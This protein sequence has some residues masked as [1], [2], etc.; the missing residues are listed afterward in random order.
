[1]LTRPKVTYSK[2]GA[3]ALRLS[4]IESMTAAEVTGT[5]NH[6][7][8][9]RHKIAFGYDLI[10]RPAVCLSVFALILAF[11]GGLAI[12]IPRLLGSLERILLLKRILLLMKLGAETLAMNGAHLHPAQ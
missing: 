2:R 5:V 1:M 9:P 11:N 10:N 6:K 8:S 3:V 7:P 4:G 12:Q